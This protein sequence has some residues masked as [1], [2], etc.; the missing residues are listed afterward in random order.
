M[1]LS[2]VN[3]TLGQYVHSLIQRHRGGSDFHLHNIIYGSQHANVALWYTDN[4]QEAVCSNVVSILERCI[5]RAKYIVTHRTTGDYLTR[6]LFSRS[7]N[8]LNKRAQPAME[9]KRYIYSRE[10]YCRIAMISY[11][12][13]WNQKWNWFNH[14]RWFTDELA[15]LDSD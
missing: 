8:R 2:F 12:I 11:F 3:T 7:H 15:I 1:L 9:E 13:N 10:A 6:R 4:R 5:H 14:R